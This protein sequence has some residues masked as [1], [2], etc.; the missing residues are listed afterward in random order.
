MRTSA[1]IK[2]EIQ[3]QFGF[4][5][6][7]F[8][9]AESTVEVLERLWQ[10]TV[11]AYLQNPLPSLFKEQLF[12]YL[13]RY[14]SVPY[15]VV[16]HACSLYQLGM[17]AQEILDLLSSQ[18]LEKLESRDA[19]A[20]P[21]A[22]TQWT[23]TPSPAEQQIWQEAIHLFLNWHGS[24]GIP[25]KLRQR[26]DLSSYTHL[27]SFLGYIKFCH[28]WVESHPELGNW[29]N[30]PQRHLKALLREEP[31]L[32]YLFQHPLKA[33]PPEIQI[34]QLF[35]VPACKLPSV[36][37]QLRTT[38]LELQAEIAER[39]R[40]EAA[41]RLLQAIAQAVNAAPDLNTALQTVLSRTCE[42]MGWD[43]GECWM[44]QS[45]NQQRLELA[46]AW[47]S[48][49]PH[50]QP[51]RAATEALRLTNKIG[52]PGRVWDSGQPEWIPDIQQSAT[53]LFLRQ[54][55]AQAAGLKAALGLPIIAEDRVIGVFTFFKQDSERLDHRSIDLMIVMA[56]QLGLAIASKQANDALRESQE[57]L[58]A[59]FNQ[60]AVG[61]AQVGLD[62]TW[63]M[64]NQKLCEIVGY[65]AAELSK[66]SF[67]ALTYQD[68]LEV[69]LSRYRQ[70][71]TGQISNYSLEKRYLRREGG[72]V[73]VNVTVSLVRDLA[74]KPKYLVTIIEDISDRKQAE[75]ALQDSEERWR[76]I[77]DNMPILFD[78]FDEQG[79]LVVWNQECERVTGY[80][81][82]E[83]L[84]N[85]QALEL[86][87][88]NPSYLEQMIS[89]WKQRG[90]NYRNW[91]WQLV[92][93]D[94]TL[95][96][97]AWSSWELQSPL[98]GWSK[99]GF[100]VDLTERE[101]VTQQI[102]E[103]NEQLEARVQERT[104]QLEV[105]N[106]ELEALCYSVS[107]DLRSPLRG[108]NGFSQA[109]LER[110]HQQLDERAQHY[111]QRIRANS[112]RLGELIDELL[113][114]S[115]VSRS[116]LHLTTVDLSAIAWDIARELSSREPERQ[117]K[118]LITARLEVKGDRR[119]LRVLLENLLE[120]AWKY[121]SRR[122]R[123]LI[124][125]GIL[126]DTRL[127]W[128][129]R[130][131]GAGFDMAYAHQLFQ[132]FQRLHSD[133]EFPGTGIGLAT[134]WRIVQLHRGQIWA[135]A[136]PDQGAT[137]Y[138]GLGRGD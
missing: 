98:P 128:F 29:T 9:P 70:I 37:Q 27:I 115:R 38:Q 108:I 51:F 56:N 82:A 33:V 135:E 114:L 58:S 60:A 130:D 10:E 125:L 100:G 134:V 65:S 6:S 30:F 138:I 61:I 93:K 1:Q 64:V 71:L 102:R 123:A 54:A 12:A 92:A 3:N 113:E 40:A 103:L 133:R 76:Q 15:C 50:L 112:Q 116:D 107:H 32:A 28:L 43:Y 94:G 42:A 63:L 105:A 119:L 126:A 17:T 36:E 35:G 47:Y 16:F 41:V 19:I 121:T 13:S 57:R 118:W 34:C 23:T 62:G 67:Q 129:V 31:R 124:E 81:K 87:Y 22:L 106:Q 120:N 5:P 25:L 8:A 75:I 83:I 136:A 53:S 110:Y 55:A 99:W 137:F 26:L 127:T 18:P 91:E 74:G 97:I 48:N 72:L 77:L 79:H 39:Q 111:L 84:Q 73:W 131:N 68:D 20:Q 24:D 66:M 21:I 86:L 109:L 90:N 44:E 78:A 96:T 89:E 11:T 117:V 2:A 45:V 46:S 4:F 52:L 104:A 59:I 132:P 69:N 49:S 101:Q 95:K 14:C 7:F 80:R 85:P 88:P 122:D